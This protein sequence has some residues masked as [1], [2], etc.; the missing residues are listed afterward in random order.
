M[1]N[2]SISFTEYTYLMNR[3]AYWLIANKKQFTVRSV[4]GYMNKAM[5]YCDLVEKIKKNGENYQSDS[6][7][8]E[9]VECAIYDNKDLSFLPNYVSGHNGTKYY[10][11]CFVSMANRVSAYEVV[12]GR[13]PAIVYI[14]DPHGNGT[15]SNTTDST[16]KMF[17]DVFG[18]VTDID[19]CLEKIQGKGYGYYY[20]SLYN[21]KT[22][23]NRIK[24][25]QGVNCTD[26]SQLFYRLGLALGYEVQFIHIKCSGGDGHVRLRLKHPKNTEGE[27]IFRDPAAVL[28]GNGIRS[29]WCTSNYTLLAYDPAWIFSDLY[30]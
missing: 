28:K 27:W 7:I 29:N 3:I 25:K 4:Y 21:T 13:S 1:S 10:K 14:E 5:E 17:T 16:L 20:N 18:S 26:S 22:T 24:N 23:I 11:N 15:T 9:F 2:D 12:N 19:S 30:Q 6:L 8:A